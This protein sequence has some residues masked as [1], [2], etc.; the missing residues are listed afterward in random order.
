[1]KYLGYYTFLQPEAEFYG[2]AYLLELRENLWIRQLNTHMNFAS[3]CV[4]TERPIKFVLY[5][6]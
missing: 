3:L 1:M 6:N 5:N 2:I 4:E